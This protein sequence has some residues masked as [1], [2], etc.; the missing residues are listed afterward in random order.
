[1]LLTGMSPGTVQPVVFRPITALPDV[2][3]RSGAASSFSFVP[4]TFIFSTLLSGI[5]L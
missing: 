1:M 3:I 2:I 4:D 5:F